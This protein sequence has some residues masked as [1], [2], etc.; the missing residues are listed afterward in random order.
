MFESRRKILSWIR[1]LTIQE[2]TFSVSHVLSGENVDL[3][4]VA[5]TVM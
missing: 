4:F 3:N 1:C 2:D 5:I